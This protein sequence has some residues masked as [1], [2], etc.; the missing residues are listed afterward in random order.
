[1]MLGSV[2]I[3]GNKNRSIPTFV[4]LTVQLGKKINTDRVSLTNITGS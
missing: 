4:E 1:M 2:F 3:L